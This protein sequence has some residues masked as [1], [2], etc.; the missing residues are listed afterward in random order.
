MESQIRNER[1]PKRIRQILLNN[2]V[3]NFVENKWMCGWTKQSDN[4]L[5]NWYM[6]TRENKIQGKIK[7]E[8]GYDWRTGLFK[9]NVWDTIP[10][11]YLIRVR[12]RLK[13]EIEEDIK[14]EKEKEKNH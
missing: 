3:G 7:I 13:K 14:K 2:Q 5:K 8:K 9:E 6:K 12:K 11:D 4:T 1:N 10:V